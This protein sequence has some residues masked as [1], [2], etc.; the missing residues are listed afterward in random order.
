MKTPQCVCVAAKVVLLF[1]AMS[2]AGQSLWAQSEVR[3]RLVNHLI[4]VSLKSSQA[5]PFDFVLDTGA[6]TTVVD[7]SIASRL[8]FV[9]L[10]GI[11]QTTLSSVQTV[12]RGSIPSLSAGSAQVDNVDVLIQDLSVLRKIDAHIE[13]IAGQNVLSHFNYLLD[14]R[15]HVIRIELSSEIQDT[16]DGD[17]VSID[18]RENRMMIASE[19]QSRGTAGLR[20][21]LDSGAN[22]LVLLPRA[23]QA[24]DL[25]KQDSGFE[26]TS[27][28]KVELHT[29][30]VHVLTVGSQ[31][32]HDV[33]AALLA[34]EPAE[35]IGDGMLPTALFQAL[36][37]NNRQGF[38]VFN[39]QVR[40][41]SQFR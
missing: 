14:Y 12:T 33:T 20:L 18:A 25:P 3:F 24:L 2:G 23:V 41:N 15:K 4:V 30:R 9:P 36:Y 1:L 26:L 10:G 11:R 7:P 27:S 38:V 19:A 34:K 22:S 6:D 5:G 37:I 13:G 29:S 21:L 17:H 8:S 40:G 28:G 32:L 16:L 39:P 31:R 35:R